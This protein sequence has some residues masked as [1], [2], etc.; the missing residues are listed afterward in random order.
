V[1]TSTVERA[2]VGQAGGRAR[3]HRFHHCAKKMLLLGHKLR[4]KGSL[5]NNFTF[6]APMHPVR[7]C[8]EN[9]EYPDIPAFSRLAGRAPQL[10]NLQ[11]YFFVNPEYLNGT[12]IF[13]RSDNTP[14]HPMVKV[15]PCASGSSLDQLTVQV[16][17]RM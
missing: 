8:C 11:T 12:F 17:R 13:C 2:P 16:W 5:K 6:W 4:S 1:T 7:P 9:S 15:I 10:P 14:A 3:S